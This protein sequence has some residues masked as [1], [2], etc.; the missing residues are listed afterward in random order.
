MIKKILKIIYKI[1]KKLVLL[2]LLSIL[3][4]LLLIGIVPLIVGDCKASDSLQKADVIIVLGNPAT[5]TCKP[6]PVM[7]NRVLK[8]IELFK[9]GMAST[10]LFTGNSV[11]NSCNEADVM[12]DFAILNGISNVD[13]IRENQATNTYQNAYFS[14]KKMQENKFKSAIIVSSKPHLKRACSVFSKYDITL[15]MVA[16]TNLENTSQK[17]L[18]FWTFAERGILTYHLIFGYDSSFKKTKY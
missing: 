3:L 6:A 5:D 2:F 13:I 8:G 14:V 18:F 10:I 11:W 4:L 7:K 15:S 17:K 12:A 16:S 9:K 1:A